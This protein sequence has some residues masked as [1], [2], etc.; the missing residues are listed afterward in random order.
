MIRLILSRIGRHKTQVTC[1]L[2]LFTILFNAQFAHISASAKK[3]VVPLTRQTEKT[4]PVKQKTAAKSK[5]QEGPLIAPPAALSKM[6]KKTVPVGKQMN[7]EHSETLSFNALQSPDYQILTGDVRFRHD[8]AYLYC[9][10]AHYY[11][12]SNSLYAYGNVHMEQ[13]DTLFLYGA[14]LY[15]DGNTKLV[16]VRE[17]VRLENKKVTLFTDSLNFDRISNIGYFFDG[18]LL[19]NEEKNVTNELSSEYG[20][21]SPETK[22]ANFKNDVKL[23]HP[24]F[25]MTNQELIYNTTTGVANIFCPTEIVADSGYV[26]SENG[27][28]NTKTE[29]SLL[30]KRSYI[31]NGHKR[32]TGDSINY[33]SK[34]G[35]GEAFGD[36][37]LND[38]TQ[39]IT[40]KGGY[41]YSEKKTNYALMTKKAVMIEHSSKD[42]LFLHADTLIARKDSIYDAVTAFH[43]VRFYRS[44]M[45]GVCDSLYYSTRDSVLSFYGKPILWSEEQQ[46]TGEFMQLLTKNNKPDQ[47]HIQKAAMVI[48]READSLYN[49]SSGKELIAYFDSSEVRRV[50]IIGNAETIYLPRDDDGK[51]IIGLNRLVGSSLNLF[52]KDKKM[53]KIVVWPQPKGTFY[54]MA[55]LPS[56]ERYLK[57]FA[58]HQDIRPTG[59]ED[60]FREVKTSLS[61]V[62]QAS[63]V[64]Q[65]GSTSTLIDQLPVK[66][67]KKP[68]SNKQPRRLSK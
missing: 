40:L 5:K 44:D 45:Q 27:W 28:Y 36:V 50:E 48:S 56:D 14:W 34:N 59:P 47:L 38:S 62:D 60:I 65:K 4:P 58:W 1:F 54:P 19:V 31:L 33:D 67:V 35:V 23:V 9:D 6:M 17:K 13:G 16:M 25:V 68:S 20:Q 41:G 55:K 24:K 18:G 46:L 61:T 30:L 11:V 3:T 22:I 12:K 26:Y 8:G 32:L 7:L 10:S 15:Y 42:T 39:Q 52:I 37:V 57:N 51:E 43:G 2:C 64:R 63:K 21:Y 66:N 53:Q 49:Q 29:K